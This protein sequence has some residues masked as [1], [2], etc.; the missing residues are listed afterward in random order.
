[1]S[2]L[3]DSLRK[4][5]VGLSFMLSIEEE[6]TIVGCYLEHIVGKELVTIND[7]FKSDQESFVE[8]FLHHFYRDFTEQDEIYMLEQ[9]H[10]NG[11]PPISNLIIESLTEKYGTRPSILMPLGRL[12]LGLERL[13]QELAEKP[14]DEGLFYIS[15][16]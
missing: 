11:M 4:T 14:G 13:N 9:A 16:R 12:K 5:L 3:R 7:Q 2:Y 8:S 1:M 6:N 15:L 10:S